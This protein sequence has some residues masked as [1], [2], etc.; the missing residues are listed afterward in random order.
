MSR[1]SRSHRYRIESPLP[2]L[3]D[4][5][6]RRPNKRNR[7]E[8]VLRVR[9]FRSIGILL[10]AFW[11]GIG[12]PGCHRASDPRPNL[13]L[14]SIDTLRSD[15]L[16]CYGYDRD[17]TP[18]LDALA[19]RGTRFESVV[20]PANWTLPSH[21]TMLTGL[22]PHTHGVVRPDVSASPRV[23]FLAEYLAGA[24][25]GTW[26]ETDGGY[27]GAAYGFDRGFDHFADDPTP[28]A[29]KLAR[30]LAQLD[31]GSPQFCFIHTYDVHCP[32]VPSA[33]FRGLF[34]SEGSEFV[35]TEGRCGNPHF[36]G[37]SL[38]AGQVSYLS[39][40]YDEGVREADHDLGWFCDELH[41]RGLDENTIVMI[42]SDH[43]EE[44]GEH[45]QIG[46][47]RTLHR[48]ALLVPW[49]V[50]GPGIHPGR[51]GTT[52]G[53]AD[54]TPTILDLA[55]LGPIDVAAGR[56]RR[57]VLRG[58]TATVRAHPQFSE[59]SDGCSL[60][61]VVADRWH[62]IVDR[63]GGRW[64]LFSWDDDRR[65]A[66]DLATTRPDRVRS[67]LECFRKDGPEETVQ[68]L[69]TALTRE[70]RERLRSLGYV[71]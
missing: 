51:V 60:V 45:G 25:Y 47:E 3:D 71:N 54:V 23:R 48:E 59:S 43:G 6:Q 65:E 15:R 5:R 8:E 26:A 58:T 39:D 37:V 41:R 50:F 22:S 56:S 34:R 2:V 36:N 16:G 69:Q 30:A 12:L 14:I 1:A 19:A 4:L 44:L 55:G 46:H 9:G 20:A 38:T 21:V 49:I 61:S 18:R 53:L 40:R 17:T 11:V 62:L 70:E 57:A 42:V 29:D 24:G 67:L 63:D 13:V 10:L 66:Q 52:V 68:A 31:S 27:V 7:V 32:Y 28:F 33:E 64:S 35:E